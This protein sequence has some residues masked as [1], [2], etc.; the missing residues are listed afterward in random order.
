MERRDF[1][2]NSLLFTLGF[3]L[4]EWPFRVYSFPSEIKIARPSFTTWW[5]AIGVVDFKAKQSSLKWIGQWDP[6]V[7]SP[8]PLP[9]L[10]D[11]QFQAMLAMKGKEDRVITQDDLKRILSI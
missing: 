8:L 5:H 3:R 7:V 11:L 10:T 9:E 6:A 1:L 2:R 4:R